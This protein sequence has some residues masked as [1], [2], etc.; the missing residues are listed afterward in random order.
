MR[1]DVDLPELFDKAFGVV[2]LVCTD[3]D[4]PSGTRQLSDHGL[5]CFTL[6]S[7]C[8]RGDAGLDDQAVSVL[9]QGVSLVAKLGL[10]GVAFAIQTG[11]RISAGGMGV[12]FELLALEVNRL[13]LAAT[14]RWW[15]VFGLE[16]LD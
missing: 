8:C 7:T 10:F 15:T 9:H 14:G 3:G 6:S 4:T 5:G 11:I 12:V 2:A 16:A 13:V 1:R